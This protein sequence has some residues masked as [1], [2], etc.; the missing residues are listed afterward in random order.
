MEVLAEGRPRHQRHRVA[1]QLAHPSAGCS[2]EVPPEDHLPGG[3][4]LHQLGAARP[5]VGQV[6]HGPRRAVSSG[7]RP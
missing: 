7:C 4:A 1:G 3:A 5:R 6:R 2:R